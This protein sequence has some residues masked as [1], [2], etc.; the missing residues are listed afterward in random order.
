M[1]KLLKAPTITEYLLL[2]AV[3]AVVIYK[4]GDSLPDT[5]LRDYGS[6][7]D[8]HKTSI[9]RDQGRVSR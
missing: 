5:E 1:K 7:D 3:I 6:P 2:V 8:V 4:M 9:Q